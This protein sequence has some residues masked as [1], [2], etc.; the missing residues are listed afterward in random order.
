MKKRLIA[1]LAVTASLLFTSLLSAG[2][3][4][5]ED[6]ALD[7]TMIAD[8]EGWPDNLGGEIGVYGSLEPDWDMKEKVPYS[9]VYEPIAPKYDSINVH[10]G[11][12]SFRLVNGLGTK[13]NESWGSFAMDM[14]PT[15]DTKVIPKKVVS[16]DASGYKYLTFWYKGAMGGENM[17][18]I[19]RDAGALNYMPQFEYALK[20]ATTDW[21]KA[22]IPLSAAGK[23]V[24][25]KALDNIGI[26]FGVDLGN[27]RGSIV[28]LDTFMFTNSK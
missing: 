5:A 18:V 2:M 15:I 17:K 19:M 21:K 11:N 6:L 12:K 3:I 9:W 7:S 10:D 22:T 26:S 13:P 14:G 27:R 1:S 16:F 23:R 24:D 20:G 28:Y 8:F 25:L 4:Y